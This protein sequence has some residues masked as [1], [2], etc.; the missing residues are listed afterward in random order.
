MF[1]VGVSIAAV[2]GT[3]A[4]HPRERAEAIVLR[5]PPLWACILGLLAPA[6]FAPGWAI[7]A[8]HVVVYALLPLGFFVLGVT[9][10]AEAE[11]RARSASRRR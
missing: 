11:D 6:S 4:S 10:A 3:V 7:D 5:N 8:S 1:T 9:L 2:F